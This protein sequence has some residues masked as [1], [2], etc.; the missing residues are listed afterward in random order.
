MYRNSTYWRSPDR[1]RA[2][3]CTCRCWVVARASRPASVSAGARFRR[4]RRAAR[5][6]HRAT[7]PFWQSGRS[8]QRSAGESLPQLRQ[9]HRARRD[10]LR[11]LRL[12][13]RV[14][15]SSDRRQLRRGG[16]ALCAAAAGRGRDIPRITSPAGRHRC[17]SAIGCPIAGCRSGCRCF[18]AALLVA[19]PHRN[20][21]RA[22]AAIHLRASMKPCKWRRCAYVGRRRCGSSTTT[23]SRSRCRSGTNSPSRPTATTAS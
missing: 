17:G 21:E 3:R 16:P 22:A 20:G 13:I 9:L 5:P 23:A 6:D 1:R 4:Q 18:T 2:L 19:L 14:A 7:C 12:Q 11:A 10:A 15:G 8:R